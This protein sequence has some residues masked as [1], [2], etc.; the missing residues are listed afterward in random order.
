MTVA[1]LGKGRSYT[2]SR[3]RAVCTGIPTLLFARGPFAVL[4][5]VVA[6]IVYSIEGFSDRPRTHVTMEGLKATLPLRANPDASAPVAGVVFSFGV[7]AASTHVNPREIR[8]RSIHA[9]FGNGSFLRR[10]HGYLAGAAAV[11]GLSGSNVVQD[12][13]TFR[14]AGT[15]AKNLLAHLLA[16]DSPMCLFHKATILL[17]SGY[18]NAKRI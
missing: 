8:G 6:F 11:L 7:V 5:R 17:G 16:Y 3:Y 13:K 2:K 4:G 9:M 18:C 1:C 12:N 10:A 14:A 15:T